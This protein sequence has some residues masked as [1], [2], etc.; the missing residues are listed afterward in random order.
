MPSTASEYRIEQPVRVGRNNLAVLIGI[1]AV[2]AVAHIATNGRYGFHRDELQ[3]LS[4]ARHLDWGFVAYPPM[5]PFL[6]HI[7]L[8]IFGLS[9]IGLR[10]FSVIAQAIVIVVSG[11]MARDLGGGRL[12]QVTTALAVALSPLPIFEATEFQYTSFGFLWYA[13]IAWFIIRLLKT[14]NPRWWLAIGAAVGLGLLTKYSIAFYIAGILG[15]VVLSRARKYLASPWFWGGIAVALL[16]FLPNLIWLARHDFISYTFLQ[17]I[18]KRDVGEGRAEGFL[19][20]QFWMCV[21]AF[22]NVVWIAGLIAYL[23][24]RRYRMLGWMYLVP[25]ALFWVGKGRFYYL[26]EAYPMLLA[27]GAVVGERWVSRLPRWGR[28]TVEATFFAGLFAVGAYVCAI[29][30]PLAPSGPLR[31]FALSKNGDLREEIGWDELVKTV[32]SIRDSLP[33]DQQ[34]NLGITVGNY[35]EQGAIEILGA[36]YHLPAPISTTNSAWLRGYPSPPPTTLI[37]LGLRREQ[38]DSIFTGCRLAGHNANSLGVENEESMY[39]PDIFVCGPPRLP[40]PQLWKEHH[41]FG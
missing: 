41:D 29:L 39:H 23:R 20:G 16:I 2:F 27:M 7:G 12:A 28:R 3:F 21:N 40:W 30:V 25:L 9:L 32:A 34:A 37:V 19:S 11:L 5:T 36:A 10:L 31:D 22:A 24:D 14:D 38:A 4:D 18:H 33:P 1:A 8:S 17:H 35:G 6:E 15:G 26:A 13:L